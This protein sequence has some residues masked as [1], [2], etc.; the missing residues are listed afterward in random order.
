MWLLLVFILIFILVFCGGFYD[1]VWLPTKRKDYKKIAILA[2]FKPG[3]ILYDLGSGTSE[4]LFYFSK[5]YKIRCVGIEISPVLY[6][7]SKIK[8]LFFKNVS[9]YY[10]DFFNS[11]LKNA[12]IIYVYLHHKAY[13][14]LIEKINKDTSD[15]TKIIIACWPFEN[16]NPIITSSDYE[17][18]LPYFLYKTPLTK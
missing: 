8:S 4:M 11:N 6:L 5:K 15:G 13:N 10:G 18:G 1:V 16:I 17:S 14:K 12:E 2:D 3:D 7:Y 9:I